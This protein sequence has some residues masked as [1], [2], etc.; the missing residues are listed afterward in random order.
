MTELVPNTAELGSGHPIRAILFNN[1]HKI[2]CNLPTNN[3]QGELGTTKKLSRHWVLDVTKLRQPYIK[4]RPRV[5]LFQS[6]PSQL[7]NFYKADSNTSQHI[8]KK[9]GPAET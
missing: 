9:H 7:Q 2:T 5:A 8:S 3:Q 6:S 4:I 1:G